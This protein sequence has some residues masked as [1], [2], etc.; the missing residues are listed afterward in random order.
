VTWAELEGEAPALARLARERLE[1]TGV[2]IL[3]TIRS[4]GSPRLDPIEP[5]FA[6]DGILIG[7]GVRTAKARDLRRDPRF[8]LH[9]TVSGPNEGE[10]DVK[11]YGSVEPSAGLAGWWRERSHDADVY[12]LVLGEAVTIEWNL[13]TSRML[14]RRWLRGRGESIDERGYP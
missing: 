7:V 5:V 6:E 8:A 4:D 11:L 12:A 3:A 9:A 2:G 1:A 10:P 14:V 13:A